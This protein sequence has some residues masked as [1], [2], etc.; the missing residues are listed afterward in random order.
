MKSRETMAVESVTQSGPPP[1]FKASSN[2]S[3][4]LENPK[5]PFAVALLFADAVLVFLIIAFVPCEF[6]IIFLS[7]FNF[8]SNSNSN[9]MNADADADADAG[10]DVFNLIIN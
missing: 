4:Y 2:S 7:F 1:R 5:M 9:S 10:A 8:N 3:S 6:D